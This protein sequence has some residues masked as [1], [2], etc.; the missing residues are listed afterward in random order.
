[1]RLL[2]YY[3][4]FVNRDMR[5]DSIKY[6]FLC[7]LHFTGNTS[8]NNK[9]N[10]KGAPNKRNQEPKTKHE[11]NFLFFCQLQDDAMSTGSCVATK[12]NQ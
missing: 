7:N 10:G 1:M 9:C 6:L 12:N 2:L 8:T 11:T 5:T 3:T 4:F